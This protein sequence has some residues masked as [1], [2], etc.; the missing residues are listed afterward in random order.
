M[1]P[2]LIL[3]NLFSLSSDE[4]GYFSRYIFKGMVCFLGS[5]YVAF[6]Y[7]MRRNAWMQFDDSSVSM[8]YDWQEVIG[9]VIKGRMIPVLIFYELDSILDSFKR[10]YQLEFLENDTVNYLLDP[11]IFFDSFTDVLT[12]DLAGL[13]WKSDIVDL[14]ENKKC[15]VI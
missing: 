15:S 2:V 14:S 7:S 4:T 9:K 5:H 1:S 8:I 6:F 12:L 10:Q 13:T 3:R 11:D